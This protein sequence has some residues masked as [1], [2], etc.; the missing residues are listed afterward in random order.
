MITPMDFKTKINKLLTQKGLSQLAVSR[1]L[2]VNKDT[3]NRWFT[4]QSMPKLED[5]LN[6]A[7]FFECPLEF[8]A[9]D[10]QDE[11]VVRGYLSLEEK[12]LL[13]VGEEVGFWELFMPE[14]G[15]LMQP[16]EDY[17][18]YLRKL[19][20][21]YMQRMS[22]LLMEAKLK[23]EKPALGMPSEVTPP[24]SKDDDQ[25]SIEPAE[26]SRGVKPPQQSKRKGNA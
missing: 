5:A 16:G 6:L 19:S 23:H 9:D 21:R 25:S 13:D 4:G 22:E 18:D 1:A 3:V 20:K 24:E 26:F 11:P 17:E 15:K 7:R 14:K 10:A 8:L 12:A 2:A